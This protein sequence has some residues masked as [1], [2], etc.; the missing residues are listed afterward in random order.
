MFKVPCDL[1]QPTPGPVGLACML[2]LLMFT[3]PGPGHDWNCFPRGN[4]FR[5][6]LGLRA[7]L[8]VCSCARA[9]LLG[10]TEL[11]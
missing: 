3:P 5:F 2:L 8:C 4:K 10:K 6:P 9:S 1:S 11:L 7:C